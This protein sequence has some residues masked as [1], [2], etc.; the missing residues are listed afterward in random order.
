MGLLQR[1]FGGDPAGNLERAET[2]LAEGDPQ[3]ALTLARRVLEGAEERYRARAE[4]LL[5]RARQAWVD[6][7]L[8][9]AEAA[10]EAGHPEDAAV[11]LTR[12]LEEVDDGRRRQELEALRRS[13]LEEPAEE[14][15]DGWASEGE[16]DEPRAAGDDGGRPAPTEELYETLLAGLAPGL[17][18]RYRGRPAAFQE[19]YVTLN[20]GRGSEALR[21]FEELAA[22]APADPVILLERGRCRLFAGDAAGARQDFEQVWPEL[23]DAPLTADGGAS[24]PSLWAEAALADGDPGAVIDRLADLA[25]P[26]PGDAPPTVPFLYAEALLAAGRLE[27]GC[28][29]LT[30]VVDL[31]PGHPDLPYL[32]ALAYERLGARG[33]AIETLERAIAPACAGGSCSRPALHVPSLRALAAL[34]LNRGGAAE[35]VHELLGLLRYALGGRFGERDLWLFARYHHQVGEAA[36]AERAATLARDLRAGAVAAAGP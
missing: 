19:A 1:L 32:L 25:D 35:R 4:D 13:L 36:A 18:G 29:F 31:F 24:L 9:Q 12:A 15:D 33:A 28:S 30:E 34:Y 23:G 27:E 11:H 10:R 3:R 7:C 20:E 8:E 21:L 17:E 2:L 16:G 14:A 6:H 26:E 5:Q 22:E